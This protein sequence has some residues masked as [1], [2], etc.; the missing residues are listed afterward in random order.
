VFIDAV[1]QSGN[2]GFVGNRVDYVAHCEDS[3]EIE[4]WHDGGIR[5]V[6]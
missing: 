2:L 3:E 6:K 5:M 4:T 1:V